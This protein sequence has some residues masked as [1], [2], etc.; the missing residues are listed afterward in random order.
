MSEEANVPRVNTEAHK[1][2][3]DLR[4]Q[5]LRIQEGLRQSRLGDSD[6]GELE[7]SEHIM[8]EPTR[9]AVPLRQETVA[10]PILREWVELE[11]EQAGKMRVE[12]AGTEVLDSVVVLFFANGSSPSFVPSMEAKYTLKVQHQ[13]YDVAFSGLNMAIAR[14]GETMLVF[15]RDEDGPG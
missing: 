5:Q 12:V 13:K 15:L 14:Y 11:H 4:A 7:D 1:I 3:E 9:L 6:M 2:P 10:K 8:A